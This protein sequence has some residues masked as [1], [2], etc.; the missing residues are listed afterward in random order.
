MEQ[1]YTVGY[2][3]VI[4]RLPS[5][6]QPP[7]PRIQFLDSDSVYYDINAFKVVKCVIMLQKNISIVLQINTKFF[8][9]TFMKPAI[10]PLFGN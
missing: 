7:D 1:R 6:F 5:P 2:N 4:G 10:V 3:H 9:K 8:Y